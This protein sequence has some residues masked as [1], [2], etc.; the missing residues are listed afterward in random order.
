MSPTSSMALYIILLIINPSAIFLYFVLQMVLV[1]FSLEDRWPIGDLV[2]GAFF[3]ISGVVVLL[4]F[5]N[6]LC[7]LA[8][9][10]ID[11]MFLGNLF[12]L[13]A[14]MMIYKY[15]DSITAEDMEFCVGGAP[16]IWHLSNTMELPQDDCKN[17]QVMSNSTSIGQMEKVEL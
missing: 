4:L 10:Y 6:Q 3:A 13:L 11:G 7:H 1:I 17:S 9:H 5:S 12:F 15:W 16:H 8:S 2:F 14:V